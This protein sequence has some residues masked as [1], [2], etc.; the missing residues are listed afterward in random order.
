MPNDRGVPR[1]SRT[2]IL[3]QR[4]RGPAGCLPRFMRRPATHRTSDNS[5]RNQLGCTPAPHNPIHPLSSHHNSSSQSILKEGSAEAGGKVLFPVTYHHT[6][7][8][9]TRF[10]TQ[11]IATT[12][13]AVC[14]R[15]SSALQVLSTG[16]QEVSQLQHP[17]VSPSGAS[18]STQQYRTA[19]YVSLH[20]N[21]RT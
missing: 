21:P 15:T 20:R 2:D 12:H 10:S 1:A 9:S 13:H 16:R 6:A 11:P 7:V 3:L 17:R 18:P 8:P 14:G 5:A 4:K 19:L